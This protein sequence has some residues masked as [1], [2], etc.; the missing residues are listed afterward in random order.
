MRKSIS[1][2]GNDH[3]YLGTNRQ[4]FAILANDEKFKLVLDGCGSMPYT[5]VGVALF[6]QEISRIPDLDQ[7]NFLK[8]INQIFAHLTRDVCREDNLM[9]LQNLSFTILAAFADSD[10]WTVF[11]CGD[12]FILLQAGDELTFQPLDDGEFPR[13]FAYNWV[14]SRILNAYQNG[15]SFATYRFSRE[16]FANV[17]VATDGLRF[18]DKI[19]DLVD[20]ANFRAR[21]IAGKTGQVEMLINKYQQIFKDDISIAF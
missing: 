19:P 8:S 12:G 3:L 1:K 10:G 7:F 6:A 4:D 5:E 15:V 9:I 16:D 18:A 21:L 17:G 14:D 2:I 11:A 20:R 13:Y